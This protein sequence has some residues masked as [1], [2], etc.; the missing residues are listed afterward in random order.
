MIV[1]EA[2]SRAAGRRQGRKTSAVYQGGY[3]G[4]IEIPMTQ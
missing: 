2:G 3:C 4:N 1:P